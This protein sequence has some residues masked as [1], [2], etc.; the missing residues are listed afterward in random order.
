MAVVVGVLRKRFAV[1]RMLAA[2]YSPTILLKFADIS[3]SSNRSMPF[4]Q[5]S[6]S[7]KPRKSVNSFIAL[8]IW[9]TV[10]PS[11]R[12]TFVLKMEVEERQECK[13]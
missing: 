9:L 4:L 7:M 2:M 5:S 6:V 3:M 12:T 13:R 1:F 11:G 8:W 10:R